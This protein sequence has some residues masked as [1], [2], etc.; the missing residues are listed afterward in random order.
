[1]WVVREIAAMNVQTSNTGGGIGALHIGVGPIDI[2]STPLNGTMI[3]YL[4]SV[5]DVRFVVDEGEQLL[6][7]S[8]DF[9]WGWRMSG[10]RLSK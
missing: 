5:I 8:S 1:V 10:Y 4:Y 2:F 7:A 3:N 6:A 9:H